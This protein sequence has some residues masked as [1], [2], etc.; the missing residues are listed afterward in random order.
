MSV[1]FKPKGGISTLSFFKASGV[2]FRF[3]GKAR[4]VDTHE[5][6]E[7][8]TELGFKVHGMPFWETASTAGPRSSGGSSFN[9]VSLE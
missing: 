4:S 3:L 5:L 2:N 9:F 8:P 1:N 7:Y 6:V